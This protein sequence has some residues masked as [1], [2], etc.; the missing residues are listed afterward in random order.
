MELCQKFESDLCILYSGTEV[1][2]KSIIDILSAGIK[3]GTAIQLTAEGPDEQAAVA[4]IAA[5]IESLI[6]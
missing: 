1:N 5:F 2:P 3:Q 6:E 4:E